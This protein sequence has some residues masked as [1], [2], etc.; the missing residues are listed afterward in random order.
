MSQHIDKVGFELEGGWDGVRGISPFT[1]ITL[2]EDGSING[3]GLRGERGGQAINATHV[4]EA[5][6]PPMSI[7]EAVDG[8]VVW[9]KWLLSHWPNAAAPNRT[10]CTCGFHIHI[11]LL[12]MKDYAFL[13]SKVFLFDLQDAMLTLGKALDL[14]PRHHFWERMEGKNRFCRFIF[15][16]ASQ[17]KVKKDGGV[18]NVR[19]GM[20]NFSWRAHGTVEFRALPTFFEAELGLKFAEAYLE[21]VNIWLDATEGIELVREVRF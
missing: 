1:D 2:I 16:A 4:G 19:Y 6:S 8:E 21:F 7:T 14:S 3:Q 5:V 20:L 12:S 13:S 11:S 10:N 17:M 15:D 18:Y 9:K